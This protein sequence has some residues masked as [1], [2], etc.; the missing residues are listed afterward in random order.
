MTSLVTQLIKDLTRLG[1]RL[2]LNREKSQNILETSTLPELVKREKEEEGI[3]LNV[4]NIMID[5][6]KVMFSSTRW[7][8]R[9]GAINGSILLSKFYYNPEEENDPAIKYFFWN[10]IRSE[11]INKLLV[12][13][14]FRV[15]NQLG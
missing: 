4:K 11:Q 5:V 7:E 6:L 12:D 2:H 3:S 9:H 15:R 10:T 8:D 14:E 1:D 13:P